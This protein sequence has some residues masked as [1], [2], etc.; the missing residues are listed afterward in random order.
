MEKHQLD[1]LSDTGTIYNI[2]STSEAIPDN[3]QPKL[4]TLAKKAA[5]LRCILEKDFKAC[6]IKWSLF[7][8][9][10]F[11]FRYESCLRPFPPAFLKNGV[12]DMDE[13]LSVVSDVP[14]LDLVLEQLINLEDLSKV[15][16]II[17]LLFY[18]LVRLKEPAL[19]TLQPDSYD[20]IL[21]YVD[22]I[23]AA[24]RPQYI[25]QVLS[26]SKSNAEQKWKDLAKNHNILYAYH[27]SHL[28]NFYSMLSFSV[29]QHLNKQ[30]TMVGNGLYLTSELSAS[31]PYSRG[32]FGWGASCIGGHIS[33]VALC[34]L[35]DAPEGINYQKPS[36]NEGY[37]GD[38]G[39][40]GYDRHT[41]D[42]RPAAHYIV[43]NSDLIRVRYILVYAKQPTLMRFPTTSGNRHNE[44]GLCQWV[45]RHKLFSILL[46]YGLMLA[47]IGFA[48]NQPIQHYYESILSKFDFKS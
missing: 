25:F 38:T 42:R 46:G 48:N 33:C 34:E 47:T 14:A 22:S 8:A 29:Q 35:I 31:L 40:A 5:H 10:A 44:R 9:A 12:K 18:V 11:S 32:G 37:S 2:V 17:H 26:T 15:S 28:E 7:V 16:D 3:S 36:S 43:T 45:S 23:E 6:D 20:Q 41:A 4:D 39:R 30:C 1:V 19:K 24:P 13:L 21:S 27:G